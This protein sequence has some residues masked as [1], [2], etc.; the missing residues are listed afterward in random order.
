MVGH[1]VLVPRKKAPRRILGFGA[2]FMVLSVL[3]M[4][5]E[6]TTHHGHVLRAQHYT[7]HAVT[8][9]HYVGALGA[10]HTGFDGLQP[11]HTGEQAESDCSPFKWDSPDWAGTHTRIGADGRC[12]DIRTPTRT[13]I[14]NKITTPGKTLPDGLGLLLDI[15]FS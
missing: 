14:A 15:A 3:A 5:L 10:V 2:L 4:L 11:A 7:A 9:L 8:K 13:A 6:Q 12:I 1:P